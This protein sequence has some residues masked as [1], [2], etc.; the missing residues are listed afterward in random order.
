[1]DY[2]EIE[3]SKL[4]KTFLDG[5]AHDIK[6]VYDATQSELFFNLIRRNEERAGLEPIKVTMRGYQITGS[7]SEGDRI[8][9]YCETSLFSSLIHKKNEIREIESK[10]IMNLNTQKW[11]KA[12]GYFEGR[13]LKEEWQESY[14]KGF[15][16]TD[17]LMRK[18]LHI[19]IERKDFN[20]IILSP[21][22]VQIRGLEFYGNVDV[23]DIVRVNKKRKKEK[24][25]ETDKVMNLTTGTVVKAKD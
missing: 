11:I 10:Y 22:P 8:R 24:T 4:P 3:E 17:P 1:M 15:F 2:F 14:K 23:G 16:G 12:Q 5:E 7:M 18:V 20:G 6:H 13:V 21:V 25:I 19:T 9:V